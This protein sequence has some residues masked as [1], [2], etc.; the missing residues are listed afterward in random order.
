MTSPSLS[1][2]TLYGEL[3]STV[4]TG[5]PNW[6]TIMRPF[7][8]AI[9]GNSSACSRMT[10][11]TAVVT[12]T[13]SISSR[14]FLSAL[15][16]MSSVTWSISCSRTKSGSSPFCNTMRLRLLDQDIPETVHRAPVPG[17]DDGRRVVLD[18][19]GGT[20]DLVARPELAPVQD[21]GVVPA[22]EVCLLR[23]HDGF[24]RVGAG[25]V[26]ALGERDALDC[27]A[28]DDPH[29]CDLQRRVGKLEV[30]ALVVGL[31]EP[32]AQERAIFA[33]ELV[34]L[35]PA[36]DLDVLQVVPAARV[37]VEPP[38]VFGDALPIQPLV[39]LGDEPIDR[40]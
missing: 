2:S 27:A 7:L 5:L 18:D 24:G 1:S 11:L 4:S 34:E 3:S 21:R 19:Y 39:G 32:L 17:L 12:R 28:P 10:G 31:L 9:R 6:P 33:R 26:L 15:S 14:M 37:Q 25:A 23:P 29:G 20:C 30:V 22:P 13:R 38:L 36:G 35:E 8:S 40:L 16:M